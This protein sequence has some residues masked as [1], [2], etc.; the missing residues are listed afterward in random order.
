MKASKNLLE[1]CFILVVLFFSIGMTARAQTAQFYPN[2]GTS[3][4]Y[5]WNFN[6][7]SNVC[8]VNLEDYDPNEFNDFV[9]VDNPT[10]AEFSV[11]YGMSGEFLEEK[12]QGFIHNTSVSYKF[13]SSFLINTSTREYVD[14]EGEGSGNG[15][16]NGY[17]DPRNMSIGTLVM[18]GMTQVETLAKENISVT[19]ISREAWKLEYTSESRN[20]T[21]HYDI[22]TGIL[23]DAKLVTSGGSIGSAAEVFSSKQELISREQVLVSTNAWGSVKITTLSSLAPVLGLLVIMLIFQRKK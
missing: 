7:F 23:L 19:G 9:C 4:I 6:G 20:E 18:V 14:E 3:S 12:I 11:S 1:L 13:M 2:K 10:Y 15:F 21:F 8:V 5:R 17:I 16:A 22:L